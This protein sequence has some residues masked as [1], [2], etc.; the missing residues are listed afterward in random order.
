MNPDS[1]VNS[2]AEPSN[3]SPDKIEKNISQFTV[4]QSQNLISNL[5]PSKAFDQLSPRKQRLESCE[6]NVDDLSPPD[7]ASKSRI[8]IYKNKTISD[9]K[10]LP[11]SSKILSSGMNQYQQPSLIQ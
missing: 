3:V 1:L 2:S 7:L 8:K 6:A 9:K 4:H 5:K 10:K 11:Q